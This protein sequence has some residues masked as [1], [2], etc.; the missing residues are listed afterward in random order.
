MFQNALTREVDAGMEEE[1]FH[2]AEDKPMVV[3]DGAYLDGQGN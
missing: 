3:G 1:R 2:T